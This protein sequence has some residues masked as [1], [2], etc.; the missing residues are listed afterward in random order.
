MRKAVKEGTLKIA[1]AVYDLAT[2]KVV[3]Q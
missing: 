3:V 1:A 2:G